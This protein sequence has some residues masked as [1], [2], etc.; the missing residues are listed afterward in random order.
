MTDDTKH[1]A[2][3]ICTYKRPRYLKRLLGELAGQDTSGLF[4]YS[5]VVADNDHLQSAQAVVADFTAA[6]PMSITYCVE[7]RQNIA[8]TRNKAIENATGDFIAFIDDDEFPT[9]CWLLTLFKAC[10]AYHVDGVLGPVKRHFDEEPPKWVVK[11]KFYERPTYPT[12]FVIDWR[13]GRT[14]NVLLKKRIFSDGAQPFRAEFLSGEDQDFFRRMIEKGHVF[15]WCNEAV[16]YEVVPPV[17]WK[18][19]FM[20][21]RALLQGTVSVIDPTLGALGITKSVIA[22]PAYT[23]ALPFALALGHHRFMTLLVKLFDHIGRLLALLGIKPIKAYV[24]D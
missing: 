14:N 20:L 22:V 1:I 16:V 2:V 10:D 18:R 21:R 13:K 4:T 8:L 12:G 11:G 24:T 19:T 3:C 17:R 15:I 6:S 7:P 5:I 9:K 23:A